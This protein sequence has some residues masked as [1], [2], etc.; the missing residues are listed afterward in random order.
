MQV[1]NDITERNTRMNSN[2]QQIAG[3]QPEAKQNARSFPARLQRPDPAEHG[4]L[5]QLDRE[6]RQSFA[7]MRRSVDAFLRTQRP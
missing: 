4:R 5:R 3:P 7:D 6:T 1:T 2:T